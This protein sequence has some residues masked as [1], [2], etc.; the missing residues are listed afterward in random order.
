MKRNMTS[1]QPALVLKGTF[2]LTPKGV[3]LRNSLVVFQF[4]CTVVLIT[5]ACFIKLQH[6]YM[7]NMDTGFERENVLYVPLNDAR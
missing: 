4:I 2:A 3:R 5:V 1:F 7:R 6:N